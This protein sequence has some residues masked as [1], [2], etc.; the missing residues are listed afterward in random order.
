MSEDNSMSVCGNI[1]RDPEL[2]FT[3]SGRAV[4][5]FGVAVNRRYQK[6][7]QWIDAEPTFVNIIAWGELG[8]HAAASLNK[9]DRVRCI[10][11]FES[12][13]WDKPDGTKGFASELIADDVCPSLKWATVEISRSVRSGG[14]APVDPVTGEAAQSRRP[15]PATAG[16]GGHSP[17]PIYGDEEPF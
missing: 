17:D 3:S 11:R 1:T 13:T 16:G 6:D 8:E 5:S 9:G 10:G 12:R 15:V 4:A 7:G 2:R 14:T